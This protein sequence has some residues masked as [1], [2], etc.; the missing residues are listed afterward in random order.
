[1]AYCGEKWGIIIYFYSVKQHKLMATFIGDYSC[2]IDDK[3]RVMLPQ[4]FK[5]ALSAEAHDTFVVKK[6]IYEKCLVLFPLDEW[7]RQV[8]I[9][10][11]NLNPY[12]K[13]H[14]NFLRRF[15][16]DTHEV[17]LDASNRLLIPK[18][19]LEEGAINKE[20]VMA[21]QDGKIEVWSKET[22]DS[23]ENGDDFADL[24]QKLMGGSLQKPDKP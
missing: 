6:D 3:G 18:R 4:A 16:K 21:G 17:A 1:V 10:K 23:I 24:A 11:V 12:N 9:I 13:E 22:Y 20:I 19:L 7:Q 5:K 15:Y 8:E 14:N 2:K